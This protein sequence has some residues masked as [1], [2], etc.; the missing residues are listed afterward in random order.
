MTGLHDM[1]EYIQAQLVLAALTIVTHVL[2]EDGTFVAKIFR[3]RDIS[4]LYAQV[5][6]VRL[7]SVRSAVSVDVSCI[8]A[9]ARGLCPG[10]AAGDSALSMQ[11]KIFFPSVNTLKPRSSRNSS[12][13]AKPTWSC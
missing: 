10:Q 13:G 1:D 9:F 6:P 8:L 2:A 5:S 4:L 3:G 12:I 7:L 11:L